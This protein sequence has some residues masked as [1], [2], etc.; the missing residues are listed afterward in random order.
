MKLVHKIRKHR[1]NCFSAFGRDMGGCF[2][3]RMSYSEDFTMWTRKIERLE[4]L[5]RELGP[6]NIS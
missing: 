6:I 5:C 2:L 3:Y 1:S 4:R